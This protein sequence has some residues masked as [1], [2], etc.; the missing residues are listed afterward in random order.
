MNNRVWIFVDGGNFHHLAI[1]KIQCTEKTFD[2]EKFTA[3]LAGERIISEQGKR[4]Y[5]GTVRERI[6]DLHSKESMS[7]QNRFFAVLKNNEWKIGTSKLK[8]R[9]ETITVD[10]RMKDFSKLKEIGIQEIIYER[11][12]EK[13]IDVM[14]A[15][16]IIAGAVE[17]LYDTAIIISSDA[18]LLPA[19][20]WVRKQRNKEVQYIGFS[21]PDPLNEKNSVKPLLSMISRTNSQRILTKDDL[22]QF[23]IP[24]Q[25]PD[26]F[27]EPEHEITDT[28]SPD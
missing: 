25:A 8:T 9:L 24:P 6:G 1:K 5:I 2:F 17:D 13:G 23:I 26:I 12:R 15:T 20:D 18:D 22:T 11:K 21:I 4:Y 19:I 16:D 10:S 28:V 7:I 14:I 3:F 27:H